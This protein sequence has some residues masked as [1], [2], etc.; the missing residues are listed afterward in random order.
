M[1]IIINNKLC[2]IECDDRDILKRI[3]LLFSYMMMNYF[4]SPAYR[5]GKWD[6]RINLF[7][8][9]NK[10]ISVG[11]LSRLISWLNIEN[12]PFEIEDN[13]TI[14]ENF[15]LEYLDKDKIL[16]TDNG[17]DIKLRYYQRDGILEYLKPIHNIK[18]TRGIFSLPP[19]SGKTLMLGT[20]GLVLNEYPII[21]IVHRIDLAYQTKSVFEKLYNT[22]V[23]IVGD[24][25]FDI[26]S[27][28]VVTTIQ[29]LC[30]IYDVKIKKDDI[31][32]GSEQELRQDEKKQFKEFI[33]TVKVVMGDECHC[34]VTEIW[35]ELPK[36]L[37]SVLYTVGCSGTPYREDNAE[38]LIEQLWGSI[39]Y[40]YTREQ[41][42]KDGYLLPT[43]VYMVML[44]PIRIN[45]CDYM[46]QKS[47]GL[48]KNPYIVSATRKLID[49]HKKKNMSSVIIVREKAQGNLIH[50]ELKC[51][52][53]HGKIKGH[54]RER[55]YKKLNEKKIMKII[56]TVTDIGVDIPSLD[57]V[58]IA[59]PSKSKVLAF[60]RNRAGTK[61][62]GKK[63]GYMFILCPQII[64]KNYDDKNYLQEHWTKLRNILSKEKSFLIKEI[65]YEDL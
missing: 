37:K 62:D 42:I 31:E 34:S 14:E 4:F 65:Q 47:E 40:E 2:H 33:S 52:Y 17:T 19:R 6:G 21:F 22:K 24:G 45:S 30:Q 61:I 51:D 27:K 54:E 38:L 8:E 3:K 56:S 46:S 12:I 18:S 16:Y 20:L 15:K 5:S 63:Y 35:G 29:S 26:D 32:I 49:R 50:K 11:L 64:T 60:Q 55:V 9:N 13:R 44:P 58:I 48:N 36:Y 59:S 25:N 1:K 43:I 10:T 23:G 57:S 39:T 53:L 41:G 7:N 28:I